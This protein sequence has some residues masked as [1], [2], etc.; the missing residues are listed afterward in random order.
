MLLDERV[1]KLIESF[2]YLQDYS[3]IY[4][5]ISPPLDPEEG[6]EIVAAAALLRG[7]SVDSTWESI[8]IRLDSWKSKIEELIDGQQHAFLVEHDTW[9]EVEGLRIP[10]GRVR[11]HIE[12]ARLADPGAVRR[13]MTSDSLLHLRLVPGDSNS[14]HRV[15]LPEAQCETSK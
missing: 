1:G 3:G 10:I 8:D 6:Q 14:L 7:E 5:E 2:A 13:A 15:V 12:T 4:W 11:T 9:L